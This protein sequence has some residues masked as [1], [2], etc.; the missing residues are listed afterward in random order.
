MDVTK[1]R[2]EG[3]IFSR[4]YLQL[5]ATSLDQN[6]KKSI[7]LFPD[8]T[9]FEKQTNIRPRMRKILYTWLTEVH[10][11]FKMREV[12]L[13]AAFQ[14]CD[15]FLSKV[16]IN[17]KKLQLVGCTSL[18]IASKYH[19]INPL[20]ASDLV[21]ISDNDFTKES[22]VAM[23]NHICEVLEW[24]FSLPNAFQF[25]DRY[26]NVAIHSF[27]ERMKNR[28]KYLARYGMER[29]HIQV[30]ALQC[31]PSFMAA[32]ALFAALKLTSHQWSRSC[33]ISSGYTERQ[34]LQKLKQTGYLSIFDMMKRSVL[35]FDSRYHQAIIRKYEN[36]ERGSVS[37]LR[38]KDKSKGRNRRGT[39]EC[40]GIHRV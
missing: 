7:E 22:I 8:P 18:W 20:L 27:K 39:M 5:I 14:I 12:V 33:E 38:R 11:K 32:G 30:K 10:L 15:R 31:C 4:E 25:L 24:S 6:E 37:T 35:D 13:W 2:R 40:T 16:N 17:R 9:Y 1:C 26:T 21:H 23:E 29:F 36:V 3:H 28:V 34:L 19:E